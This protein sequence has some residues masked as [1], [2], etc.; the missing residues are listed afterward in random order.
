MYGE[1]ERDKFLGFQDK[2]FRQKRLIGDHAHQ[3]LQA[4]IPKH[5]AHV[6]PAKSGRQV[7]IGSAVVGVHKCGLHLFP[8]V[9]NAAKLCESRDPP[10]LQMRVPVQATARS[11]SAPV[12]HMRRPRAPLSSTCSSTS[13]SL[14]FTLRPL[15]G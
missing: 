10:H 3:L 6:D 7:S 13:L 2:K 4:A 8:S 11:F 9:H 1:R 12:S 14:G 5:E 15:V